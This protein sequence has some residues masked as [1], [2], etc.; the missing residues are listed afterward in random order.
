M[1]K[2]FEEIWEKLKTERDELRVQA[3][4]ATAEVKEELE[5]LEKAWH[6]VE[7]R[8]REF[9]EDAA[10]V[11]GEIHTSTKVVLEELGTAY[12][13]IKSRLGSS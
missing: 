1:N 4:L 9:K 2:D 10:E 11:S 7:K 6:D 13:R 3:H 12:K 8:M 5:E